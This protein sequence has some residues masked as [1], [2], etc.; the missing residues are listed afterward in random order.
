MNVVET[1]CLATG[2]M[3][4]SYIL[5]GREMYVKLYERAIYPLS[6]PQSYSFNY[7]SHHKKVTGNVV[8]TIALTTGY[9]SFISSQLHSQF[10]L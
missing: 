5:L 9:S 2:Y 7:I 1:T 6:S 8:E 3:A 10:F 4:R